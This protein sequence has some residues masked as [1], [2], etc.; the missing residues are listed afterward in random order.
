MSTCRRTALPR[1][2]PVAITLA[3]LLTAAALALVPSG[4]SAATPSLGQLHSE[5]GQSEARAS[6]LSSSISSLNGVIASLGS[7]ISLVQ[8]R[9]AAVSQALANDRVKL[10]KT[11][12][13]LRAERALLAKLQRRLA[14]AK[15]ILRAQLVSNYEGAQPDLV[16]VVLNANG[17][18]NLLDQLNYLGM[19]EQRQQAIISFTRAARAQADQAAH[20]L[21]VLQTTDRQMTQGAEVQARALAGMNALL[22]SKQSA[23]RSARAAQQSALGAAQVHAAELRHRISAVEAAQAAAAARAA[24]AAAAAAQRAAAAAPTAPASTAPSGSGS[25][26]ALGP[27]GGW[28]IPYAIVL[29]ESGGQNLPPNSAGASGYYQIMPATWKLFGGSGPAAYLAPKAEQDAVAS[30]IWNGGAGASNWV[31]AGIVGIH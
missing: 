16:S 21:V 22:A 13:S 31:C 20:R 17:F 29:C 27:S 2:V 23:M 6:S 9:E 15:S 30:R 5:L 3:A 24:A 11:Q 14:F 12:A 19:A 1:V 18:T 26:V 10:A 7:Q 8:G 4:T 28:A 25:T